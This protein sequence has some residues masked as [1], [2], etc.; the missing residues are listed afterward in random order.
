MQARKDKTYQTVTG[1]L[2]LLTTPFSWLIFDQAN[3]TSETMF[4]NFVTYNMFD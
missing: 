3:V 4:T 1:I 2:L